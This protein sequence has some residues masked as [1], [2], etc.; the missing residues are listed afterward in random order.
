[1]NASKASFTNGINVGSSGGENEY[2]I[3]RT[4]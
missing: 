1:M 4:T 3:G 2:R